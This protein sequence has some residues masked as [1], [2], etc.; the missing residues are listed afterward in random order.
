MTDAEFQKVTQSNKLL[1]GPR[2]LLLCGFP[3]DAQSKFIALLKMIGLSEMPM[4]W[5]TEDQG[6]INV[7]ELVELEDGTGAGTSSKLPRSIIMSGITQKELHLLMAGCRKSGMKQPLWATL[8]P[9]SETWS[10][11]NLLKELAAEHR[12]MQERKQQ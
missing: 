5:V 4:I 6:D 8:T 9:T 11:Q 2:K 12:T 10:I 7:G 3:A 1:Y